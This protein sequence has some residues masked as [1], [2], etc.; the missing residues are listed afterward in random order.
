MD[1]IF[2]TNPNGTT[3]SVK[4]EMICVGSLKSEN[5]VSLACLCEFSNHVP[6]MLEWRTGVQWSRFR[7]F[8][9]FIVPI[10]ETN[11]CLMKQNS[12]HRMGS[13][14]LGVHTHLS[15]ECITKF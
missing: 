12:S 6:H 11:L 10:F 1:D 5:A 9:S 3:S 2:P 15:E 4:V 7:R 13:A 14:A 8:G